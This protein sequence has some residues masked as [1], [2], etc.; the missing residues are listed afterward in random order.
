MS[1]K[2]QFKLRYDNLKKQNKN[3]LIA[4]DPRLFKE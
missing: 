1:D 4:K 2:E 3:D